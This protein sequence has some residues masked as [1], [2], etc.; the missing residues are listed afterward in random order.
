MLLP[1]V[2]AQV[3]PPAQIAGN[4]GISQNRAVLNN[5]LFFVLK[6]CGGDGA[7]P[8]SNCQLSAGKMWRQQASSQAERKEQR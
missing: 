5:K 4:N 3:R 8:F 6:R 7:E 1:V 2:F